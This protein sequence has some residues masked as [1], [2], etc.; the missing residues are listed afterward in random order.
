MI[1]LLCGLCAALV[2]VTIILLCKIV[3]LRSA[4]DEIGAAF[5]AR[6]HEDT[7]VGI[8]I[9][10]AD[11]RMRRLAA[12]IDRQLKHLRRR[13]IRFTQG[14]REL[15]D[16][17]TN[18][19]HDLRTPL[20]AICG[21]MELL[22]RTDIP[23]DVRKYLQIIANRIDAMKQLTEELF[24]YSVIVSAAEDSRETIVLNRA[25]QECIAA[26]YSALTQRGIV[27]KVSIAEKLTERLLNKAALARILDNI[28]SNA[29]KYSDGDLFIALLPD[30]SITFRNHAKDLDEISIGRLFDRFYTVENGRSGTG[31][32]LSIA[33]IL[34]E[35]AGGSIRAYKEGDMFTIELLF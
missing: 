9:S 10:T 19:A 32:G 7:N 21:Y 5:S 30:G 18:I 24:R 23:D 6:I 20:T 4:A 17:I 29:L 28:M 35:Q 11:R 15:K 22:E 16:A 3:C 8:D 14:D 13:H 33:K 2:I 12:E 34:T 31:L 25:L 27:P 1:W 26:H